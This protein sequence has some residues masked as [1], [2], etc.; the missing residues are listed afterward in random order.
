MKR[1]LVLLML[2][3]I[4]LPINAE[5]PDYFSIAESM[6]AEELQH[7]IDNGLD[8]NAALPNGYTPLE[9][10]A[11]YSPYDVIITLLDNGAD[12]N[13]SDSNGNGVII[14]LIF[15]E[16]PISLD[17]ARELLGKIS[18]V[19]TVNSQGFTPLFYAVAN[20]NLDA[21]SL[22]IEFGADVNVKSA[23][24]D[25]PLWYANTPECVTML[26]EAGADPNSTVEYVDGEYSLLCRYISEYSIEYEMAKALIEAGADVNFMEPDGM[27]PFSY[28]LEGDAEKEF[29]DFMIEHGASAE[30]LNDE[31]L[32]KLAG[33]VF[34]NPIDSDT[35]DYL[36]SLKF[37]VDIRDN[38]GRSLLMSFLE[39]EE[40]PDSDIVSRLL[41]MGANPNARDLDGNTPLM[42][43][44]ADCRNNQIIELLLDTGSDVNARNED[45][46]TPLMAAVVNKNARV[47][48]LIINA[49]ADIN[50]Q[51][52]DGNTALFYAA[53]SAVN[54]AVIDVL[55][56]AGADATIVNERGRK[57]F[58]SASEYSDV[59]RTPAFWRLV[60]AS[61]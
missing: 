26:I 12:I 6:T 15:R 9:L 13:A 30:Y 32:R 7:L 11:L 14:A 60:D 27:T 31:L 21:V 8:V 40:Y 17:E 29:I 22:L 19:D 28:A 61:F 56:E 39:Y 44:A 46:M 37:P 38:E 10:A 18:D 57:A 2:I 50:A 51:D 45:L 55:L 48:E 20:N 42:I 41:E 58:E 34:S 47:V 24:G 36:A 35:L 49:G 43:A 1:I 53:E 4:L 52:E 54:P 23:Y 16:A 25:V 33:D 5:E 59:Y 3:A